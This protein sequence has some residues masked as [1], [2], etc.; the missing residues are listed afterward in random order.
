MKT[1]TSKVE[2][3]SP[4]YSKLT[5]LLPS[6]NKTKP[7]FQFVKPYEEPLKYTK[8]NYLN[9]SVQIVKENYIT[10]SEVQLGVGIHCTIVLVAQSFNCP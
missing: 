4:K 10:F 9:L 7:D 6:S 1:S 3:S 2:L 8:V 5:G